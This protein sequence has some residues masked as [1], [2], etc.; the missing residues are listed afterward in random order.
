MTITFSKDNGP[1]KVIPSHLVLSFYRAFRAE[2]W[3]SGIR[4]DPR[5]GDTVLNV[6]IVSLAV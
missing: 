1:A 6:K 5:P 2:L 3:E 4:R